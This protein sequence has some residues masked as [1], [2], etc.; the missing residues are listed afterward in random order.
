MGE[1]EKEICAYLKAAHGQFISRREIARRAGGKR[2]FHD[3]PQWAAPVLEKLVEKKIIESNA[4]G[5]FRLITKEESKNRRKKWV[6][7]HMK[8]ILEKS[9]QDFTHVIDDED[10]E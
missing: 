6:S 4:T 9:G 5:Q 3:D 2:R 7:P 1:Q 10:S 8:R